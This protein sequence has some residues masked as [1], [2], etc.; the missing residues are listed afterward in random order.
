MG[1]RTHPNN[2]TN[3]R[4]WKSRDLAPKSDYY[5]AVFSAKPLREVKV[6]G[7]EPQNTVGGVCL[8]P[9]GQALKGSLGNGRK[10][11]AENK[12]VKITSG[13]P[14]LLSQLLLKSLSQELKA[15]L[16]YLANSRPTLTMW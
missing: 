7:F 16:G 14:G 10:Q 2:D 3:L 9:E 8:F 4:R 5:C 13:N 12:D 15:C 1:H 6:K 11:H